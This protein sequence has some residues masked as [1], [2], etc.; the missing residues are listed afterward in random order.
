MG[1]PELGARSITYVVRERVVLTAP[2]GLRN[3]TK[4]CRTSICDTRRVVIKA[5]C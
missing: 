1:A 2:D 3:V 5:E 4:I